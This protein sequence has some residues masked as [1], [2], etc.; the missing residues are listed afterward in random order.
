MRD[1]PWIARPR[2]LLRRGAL[3]LAAGAGLGLLSA[4]NKPA[5]MSVAPQDQFEA[6]DR[7]NNNAQGLT[8]P[9]Q[10]AALVSF[11][12]RTSDGKT[13]E[14]LGHDAT[15]IFSAP[16]CLIFNVKS[17]AGVIAQFGSND[18]RYWIWVEPEVRKLWWGRWD[19]LGA[20]GVRRLPI[21]PG[22][23]LDALMLRPLPLMI[24][25]GPSAWL[26]L[27]GDD[28]RLVYARVR[29]RDVTSGVREIRLQAHPPYQPREIIDFDA[30]GQVLMR[31]VLENYQR[32]GESGPF[33]PRKYQV[34]W[35]RDGAELRMDVLSARF[36]DDLDAF[37]EFPERWKGAVEQIDAQARPA[38]PI[39][40]A[41][42]P[43]APAS[44]PGRV[45]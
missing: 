10:C 30:A 39:S 19:T 24:G 7:I 34:T 35:P 28:H 38:G 22:D 2:R 1:E 21:P 40:P 26:R 43:A 3:G 8:Q 44:A 29:D 5:Q 32:V 37:C 25:E 23:L 16:R 33:T 9:L 27:D 18:E 4:C 31:A 12:F 36:R 20:E 11:K 15:L 14:Y 6:L 13:H 41:S 17:L 42:R 45:P